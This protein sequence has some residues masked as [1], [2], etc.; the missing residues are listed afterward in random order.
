M[1]ESEITSLKE[2]SFSFVAES[3]NSTLAAWGFI[4]ARWVTS[5]SNSDQWR[6]KCPSPLI[7]SETFI[8]PSRASRSVQIVRRCPLRCGQGSSLDKTMVRNFRWVVSYHC[9]VSVSKRKN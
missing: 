4:T 9:L 2:L 6:R 7:E 3:C 5:K 1:A 8:I